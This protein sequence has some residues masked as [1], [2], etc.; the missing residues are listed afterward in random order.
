[1]E[2][3]AWPKGPVPVD[4]HNE[5]DNPREDWEGNCRFERIRVNKGGEMLSVKATDTFN[6]RHFSKRELRIMQ[7]LA[8]EFRDAT[9][10]EMI[11]R[12][13]LENLPWH[14][15]YEVEKRKQQNIPYEMSLRRQDAEQ[16]G[17]SIKERRE[18]IGVLEK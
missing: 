6:P 1:M 12:T 17:E 4:L 8:K 7:D 11:E 13:H 16:M 14:Q 3:F 15:I 2:Y 5:L 18:I 10:D 9:A